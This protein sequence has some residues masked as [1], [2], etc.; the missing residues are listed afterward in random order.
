MEIEWQKAEPPPEKRGNIARTYSYMGW[1]YPGHGIISK[2]NRSY[3]RPGTN[4]T[5][6]TGGNVRGAEGLNGFRA[7]RTHL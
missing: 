3:F 7:I 6:L 1:T 2:K 5:R 4:R